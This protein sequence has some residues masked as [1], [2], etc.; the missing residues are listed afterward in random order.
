M[1]NDLPGDTWKLQ[2]RLIFIGCATLKMNHIY[3]SDH[4]IFIG[5]DHDCH[6]TVVTNRDHDTS[7]EDTRRI[8]TD[9]DA[10]IAIKRWTVDEGEMLLT[11]VA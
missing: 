11:I 1:I 7:E 10:A 9:L 4:A 3:S 6:R 5:H 2:E 8:L